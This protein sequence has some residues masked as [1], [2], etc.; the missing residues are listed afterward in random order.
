MS[1]SAA[2]WAYSAFT[3]SEP[4]V[5]GEEAPHPSTFHTLAVSSSLADAKCVPRA[6][7]S[8]SNTRPS[9]PR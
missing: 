4:S 3:A 5:L 8:R 7:N 6:L 2:A 9:C 1:A